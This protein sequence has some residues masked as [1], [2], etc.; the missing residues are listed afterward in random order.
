MLAVDF[1]LLARGGV[2]A[3][4]V[5]QA[6]RNDATDSEQEEGDSKH[7]AARCCRACHAVGGS[8]AVPRVLRDPCCPPPLPG[9]H[10]VRG[11]QLVTPRHTSSV[12]DL[13]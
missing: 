6:T 11:G 12:I 8:S 9:Q 4:F 1:F 2:A 7:F 3:G 13:S 10:S 5:V